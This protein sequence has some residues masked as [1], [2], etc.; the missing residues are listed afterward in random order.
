MDVKTGLESSLGSRTGEPHCWILQWS[1]SAVG[2]L[3][4]KDALAKAESLQ[5][6]YFFASFPLSA[7][8]P[9]LNFFGTTQ[10]FRRFLE[11]RFKVPSES[12]PK[13]MEP[14]KVCLDDVFLRAKNWFLD[15]TPQRSLSDSSFYLVGLSKNDWQ[16]KK[17]S[18]HK[19]IGE[20]LDAKR[21]KVW[22]R[23][24][25]MV[26]F[27][28][29]GYYAWQMTKSPRPS[30]GITIVELE[31]GNPHFLA[32]EFL[33]LG[34]K[35]NHLDFSDA[36]LQLLSMKKKKQVI[37]DFFNLDINHLF[38]L[39]QL[40][41]ET[42]LNLNPPDWQVFLQ[43]STLELD[44]E[45][46]RT[47]DL[48]IK[49]LRLFDGLLEDRGSYSYFLKRFSSSQEHSKY[50]LVE[51]LHDKENFFSRFRTESTG[52]QSVTRDLEELSKL[53]KELGESLELER[54]QHYLQSQML[55]SYALKSIGIRWLEFWALT[56]AFN[57]H[58][59]QSL[60]IK[61]L[62]DQWEV[63]LPR[64]RK[65]V[66]PSVRL[67]IDQYEKLFSMSMKPSQWVSYFFSRIQDFHIGGGCAV[68]DR[69]ARPLWVEPISKL[70]QAIKARSSDYSESVKT[71][72]WEGLNR[73][74]SWGAIACHRQEAKPDPSL[75]TR[76]IWLNWVAPLL[77]A[78]TSED[79]DGKWTEEMPLGNMNFNG[80]NGWGKELSFADWMTK[81]DSPTRETRVK[82]DC[83]APTFYAPGCHIQLLLSPLSLESKWEL[84]GGQW[85]Q[86]SRDQKRQV[87]PIILLSLL[88]YKQ[89]Q[90]VEPGDTSFGLMV[91]KGL[92]WVHEYSFE[93]EQEKIWFERLLL[94]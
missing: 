1:R 64:L 12:S 24:V 94:N 89:I 46:K 82:L 2:P 20:P 93:T 88:Q 49:L 59:P 6:S 72:Y 75:S 4:I 79:L 70:G 55:F 86:Y 73:S 39:N 53:T 9:S 78:L 81:M 41:Q 61:S 27:L 63:V 45:Q 66:S 37:P 48:L 30:A 60:L 7:G 31:P 10:E 65:W 13:T 44:V 50:A 36:V 91:Q 87:A 29:A 38:F 34:S 14:P 15:T 54:V 76:S 51:M 22:I 17:D 69:V 90:V 42:G 43:E 26:M 71:A 25:L 85:S 19:Q 5:L 74:K 21:S 62:V 3:P 84:F 8:Q 68:S 83:S 28:T 40:S 67:E 18:W 77:P 80:W 92:E 11:E 16:P 23:R 56:K 32:I 33:K 47:G 35:L 52:N 57:D 58:N